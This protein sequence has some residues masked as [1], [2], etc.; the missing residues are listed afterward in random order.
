MSASPN[1]FRTLKPISVQRLL[2][3]LAQRSLGLQ[4]V[5][6]FLAEQPNA[7]Q[8]LLALKVIREDGERFHLNFALYT[9]DDQIRIRKVVGPYADSLAK[10]LLARKENFHAALG[11]YDVPG[12]DP[13]ELSFLLLGCISLDWDGLDL[14]AEQGYR[15]ATGQHPDGAYVPHAEEV[16]SLPLK[17]IYWGSRTS[18]EEGCWFTSFGDDETRRL[19]PSNDHAGSMFRMM[20]ALRE[21]PRSMDE[22]GRLPGFDRAEVEA[23]M[24]ILKAYGWVETRGTVIRV[25]I[26]VLVR[27]DEPMVNRV[28]ALGRETISAWLRQHYPALKAEL[29]ELSYMRS[30][31]PFPEGFTM[32]WH[33]LFGETNRR[34]VAAGMFADPYEASRPFK[35]SLPMIAAWQINH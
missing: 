34:L 26:P 10:A 4:E 13:R 30:G 23:L 9:K 16:G 17:G 3:A 27:K 2:L 25:R 6:G 33:Y 28:R 24:P 22:L 21:S 31:V 1:Y 29:G 35:G 7:L 18:E 20:L 11:S 14:T 5:K 12:V 8:D 15:A 32:I 19:T